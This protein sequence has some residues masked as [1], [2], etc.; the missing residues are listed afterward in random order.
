MAFTA[1]NIE[2]FRGLRKLEVHDLRRVNLLVGRNNS[3]K[4]TLLEA[5]ELLGLFPNPQAV[6]ERIE[7]R[8]GRSRLIRSALAT[9]LQAASQAVLFCTL[10]SRQTDG[11]FMKLTDLRIQE[12][13]LLIDLDPDAY[14]DLICYRRRQFEPL[15]D[16]QLAF[17]KD[18]QERIY[19][20]TQ[21]Y[22][23]EFGLAASPFHSAFR[24]IEWR[25][26]DVRRTLSPYYYLFQRDESNEAIVST[27]E[28][29]KQAKDLLDLNQLINSD[30]VS[31]SLDV[32]L[33]E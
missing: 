28:E 14:E 8:K 20:Q 10:D 6:V 9:T 18:E 5:V 21:T 13:R 25:R 24:V 23:I 2:Q 29:T 7:R 19:I 30:F 26:P 32:T 3:G 16:R 11:F 22:Q 31:T 12:E 4:T 33:V 17:F 1:L 15:A 27:V